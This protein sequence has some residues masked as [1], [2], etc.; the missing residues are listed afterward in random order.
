MSLLRARRSTPPSPRFG[1]SSRRFSGSASRSSPSVSRRPRNPAR[2]RHSASRR[3]SIAVCWVC[4]AQ[5]GTHPSRRSTPTLEMS[6]PIR[7]TSCRKRGEIRGD[8]DDMS[9]DPRRVDVR[10]PDTRTDRDDI[11]SRRV[12]TSSHLRSDLSWR[13]FGHAS[14]Q[15][16]NRQKGSVMYAQSDLQSP[17]QPQRARNRGH[18]AWLAGPAAHTRREVRRTRCDADGRPAGPEHAAPH[19]QDAGHRRR[20]PGIARRDRRRGRGARGAPRPGR[21][22]SRVRPE[23][24]R[25][26]E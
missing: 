19:R 4:P 3:P 18:E 9:S 22:L 15:R 16:R 12:A 23:R 7:A 2:R 13:G 6:R 26:L 24:V 25:R 17:Q 20:S 5:S 1:S 14:N 11:A 8:R 10:V 21:R